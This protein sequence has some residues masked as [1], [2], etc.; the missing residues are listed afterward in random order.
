MKYKGEGLIIDTLSATVF[1]DGNAQ[2]ILFVKG[3]VVNIANDKVSVP[4]MRA[5]LRSTNGENGDEWIISAPVQE[6]APGDSFVFSSD[7]PALPN[8]VGSVNL[9]FIAAVEGE[10]TEAKV[11]K[12]ATLPEHPADDHVPRG[13]EYQAKENGLED[14]KS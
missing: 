2:D 5:I 1:K 11:E 10:K 14:K 12:S 7:Y 9:S 13:P 8:G 6:V 4:K 3:R